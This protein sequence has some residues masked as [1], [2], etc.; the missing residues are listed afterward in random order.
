MVDTPRDTTKSPQSGIIDELIWSRLSG[1]WSRQMD[2]SDRDAIDV[3]YESYFKVLDAEYVRLYQINDSKSLAT[4]PIFTQRRWVRLD[5]NRYNELS[6]WLRFLS[7]GLSGLE[8]SGGFDSQAQ[9]T[10]TAICE[11]APTNHSKHWH[12]NIPFTISTTKPDPDRRI[13]RVGY[14]IISSLVSISRMSLDSSGRRTG[15]RLIPGRGFS[16]RPDGTSIEIKNAVPGEIYEISVGVDLSGNNYDGV[17]PV[18]HRVTQTLGSNV[19]QIPASM[20]TGHPVHV[21]IVRNPPSG[22]A[23]GLTQTNNNA[24][25]MQRVSFQPGLA[26]D[27]GAQRGTTNQ[28]VLPPGTTITPDDVVLVF[29][30]ELGDF[31]TLHGHQTAESVLDS[32]NA[33]PSGTLSF[34]PSVAVQRGLFGSVGA[35]GHELKLFL[36]GKLL[37]PTEYRYELGSNTFYLKTPLVFTSQVR[38]DVHFTEEVRSTVES[39]PLL[40]LHQNCVIETTNTEEEFETFDDGGEFDDEDTNPNAIFDSL[41]TSNVVF[42]NFEL[43]ADTVQVYVDGVLRR[44]GSDYNVT[45]EDGRTR[46][47]FG[48]PIEGRSIL[49]ASEKRTSLFAFGVTDILGGGG[50][51]YGFTTDSLSGALN[52]LNNLI[53]SFEAFFGSTV[54]N[55]SA[56]I[57][58]A[59]VAAAGG[60]PL[61]TLF[62][63][64]F[65]KYAGLPINSPNLPNLT[66]EQARNIESADTQLAAIP[67]MVDHVM[68][69]TV[70]LKQGKDYDVVGGEILS[71]QD[72]LAPR[73]D[74][75]QAPGVWWCP[76]VV[77]DEKMLAKNFGALLGDVRDSSI[78]YR[79]ALAANL[80]LRYG[81]PTARNVAR[82]AAIML[83]SKMI[84][85]DSEVRSIFRKVK[86]YSVTIT[87]DAGLNDQAVILPADSQVPTNGQP[88]VAGQS[89]SRPLVYNGLLDSLV[90]W[91]G[92]SL[93]VA[94]DITRVQAG[95]VVRITMFDPDDLAAGPITILTTVTHS[96]RIAS[97]G[98]SN[99]VI[100]LAER[101]DLSVTVESEMQA[102][103]PGPP[104]LAAFDGRVTNV[105]T[106]RVRVI[107]TEFEEFEVPVESPRFFSIG[108]PVFRG[109]P[110][111][112]DYAIFYD[113]ESRPDWYRV[114]PQQRAQDWSHLLPSDNRSLRRD[115]LADIRTVVIASATD[116]SGLARASFSPSTPLPPRGTTVS[117]LADDGVQT[118]EFTV[119]GVDGGQALL[120]PDP[121]EPVAGTATLTI[122]DSD[123][124]SRSSEYFQVPVSKISG[125][126]PNSVLTFDSQANDSALTLASTAGFPDAGSIVIKP[127]VGGSIEV[128]YF[129]KSGNRL[130]DLAWP[131]SFPSLIDENGV[132][133]PK[134][135]AGSQVIAIWDYKPT[136]LN[137]AFV[138]AVNRRVIRDF[139]TISGAPR[140]DDDTA[141]LYYALLKRSTAVIETRT[142]TDPS[143][144]VDVLEETMPPG[145]TVI[146]QSKHVINDTYQGQAE[147]GL[148][149]D[150]ALVFSPMTLTLSSPDGVI[151]SSQLSIPLSSTS[152]VLEVTVTDPESTDH[153]YQWSVRA[154]AGASTDLAVVDPTGDSTRIEGLVE[155]G[156]YIVSVTV[157]NGQGQEKTA[158]VTVLVD[159]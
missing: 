32:G 126:R 89:L 86:S 131:K 124:V 29:S 49:I 31:D 149:S 42:V 45:I 27:G 78:T 110:I 118:Y 67:F 88:M 117:V 51:N 10:D 8:G 113:D 123:G 128:Q 108:Q 61:L 62:Y 139:G 135:N 155:G 7:G 35:L 125:S 2:P 111:R 142:A 115:G 4:C 69:P 52:D 20:D 30:T 129:G 60:N 6:A 93:V 13:V 109:D 44:A 137:P 63:D 106:N 53:T 24:F 64:E 140:I 74:D 25:T 156:E 120:F 144:L 65:P 146:L 14:P 119:Y 36:D 41:T 46:I 104:P 3:I 9:N 134:I 82:S 16:I 83:G 81:G 114:T 19:V 59:Y 138:T 22:S 66:A 79:D 122:D 57:E 151:A 38:V 80:G 103:H 23:G 68:H 96:A 39:R 87:D 18:V 17:R 158:S 105:T 100:H 127:N 28:V 48:E 50:L 99:T 148:A 102:F 143:V 34:S 85:Q 33:D 152:V 37:S 11:D 130:I 107:Q 145:T 132:F 73:G 90:S 12:I 21:M 112:P 154:I 43:E 58:A 92:Q 136:L 147:D 95:D 72:L 15:T 77:L 94:G 5:L 71:G 55:L 70:R 116:G 141:P 97:P 54:S 40:H 56:L 101:Y 75:D 150:N 76:L 98:G 91:D 84:T 153:E 1:F 47:A 159:A 133:D 157:L 26:S 121:G